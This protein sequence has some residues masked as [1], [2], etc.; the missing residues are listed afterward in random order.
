[1]KKQRISSSLLPA[2]AC[3]FAAVLA[4]GA[5]TG[6]RGER[7][8][9]RPRQF[10]PDLDD[11]P[12]YKAQS[13]SNFFADGRS[14]RDPVRGTIPFGAAMTTVAF[15]GVDFARRDE[16]LKAD[17]RLFTGQEPVLDADGNPVPDESG[18]PRRVYVERTPIEDILRLPRSSP[19]FSAAYNDFLALGE[20]KFNIFCLPCHGM[21]GDG[22]GTVGVRWS[23]PL[24]SWHD[25][26]YQRGGEKGSDGLV[27][28]TIRYGVP[29][30]G[31]NVPYP[32]KM[33]AYASKISEREAWAIVEYYRV[34]QRAGGSP[35]QS[36]PERDRQD[37]ERRRGATP[38]ADAGHDRKE[39]SS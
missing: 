16:Y 34:L 25:A 20:K 9:K 10:F 29:N 8:D 36:V 30:V 31:E 4:L 39:G 12:K 19:G 7:T 26:Q 15:E 28:H 18:L 38:Q 3:G 21:T 24:P 14:M 11:Q 27:F 32:L 5:M 23:Y 13:S 33:P 22:R 35:I 37:L 2:L 6:C 1:M 17:E